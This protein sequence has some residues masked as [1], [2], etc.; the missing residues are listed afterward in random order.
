[1]QHNKFLKGKDLIYLLC[2]DVV[3]YQRD[4]KSKKSLIATCPFEHEHYEEPKHLKV[5]HKGN[6]FYQEFSLRDRINNIRITKNEVEVDGRILF[7]ED[8]TDIVMPIIK[9]K[10]YHKLKNRKEVTREQ[11]FAQMSSLLKNRLRCRSPWIAHQA[12]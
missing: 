11:L 7:D 8:I 5:A 4:L 12:C 10:L 6:P 1:M 9:E 2:E 3:F